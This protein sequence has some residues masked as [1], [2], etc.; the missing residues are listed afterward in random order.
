MDIEIPEEYVGM[1]YAWLNATIGE[2][3]K[4]ATKIV[5]EIRGDKLIMKKTVSEPKH[6]DLKDHERIIELFNEFI[7]SGA[8]GVH[9]R[10][11]HDS[12][13]IAVEVSK[14]RRWVVSK[15]GNVSVN[16][17]TKCLERKGIFKVRMRFGNERRYVYVKWLD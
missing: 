2:W 16:Y 10:R 12:P 9:R 14:F 15:I 11:Y 3:F 1:T 6:E 5:I 13:I 7:A 4:D 8:D 17:I